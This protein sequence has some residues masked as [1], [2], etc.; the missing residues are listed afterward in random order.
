MLIYVL[1]NFLYDK[2]I[3]YWF[4]HDEEPDGAAPECVGNFPNFEALL[5]ASMLNGEF[6]SQPFYNKQ[7]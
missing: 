5:K 7:A 2:L 1:Q 6:S 3:D 4:E